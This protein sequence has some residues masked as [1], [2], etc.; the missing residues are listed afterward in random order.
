M[1]ALAPS[2][3]LPALVLS[4]QPSEPIRLAVLPLKV[5]GANP[6]GDLTDTLNTLVVQAALDA[7]GFQI[8][9]RQQ[10][11]ALL[12][13]SK[14]QASGL[15]DEASAATLGKHLGA[16]MV[17]VGSALPFKAAGDKVGITLSVRLVDVETASV[18]HSW[19]ETTR[20]TDLGEAFAQLSEK[21][22][23]RFT[24][25]ASAKDG[26]AQPATLVVLQEGKVTRI[27]RG[28]THAQPESWTTLNETLNSYQVLPEQA[29]TMLRSNGRQVRTLTLPP[30]MGLQSLP[31]DQLKDVGLIL[32]LTLDRSAKSHTLEREAEHMA[33]LSVQLF[34]MPD[35]RQV[36]S[37]TLNPPSVKAELYK[38]THPLLGA[39]LW[40]L[41]TFISKLPPQLLEAVKQ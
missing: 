15:V 17:V 11:Q 36:H 20:Q 1:R 22:R 10:V 7:K 41:R 26:K 28:K 30:G 9:E 24:Q 3:A 37:G 39:L 6:F 21:L 40:E 27:H 13:E 16:R 35:R 32:W 34:Q 5:E 19:M 12:K 29:A 14:Y 25:V 31:P 4:A 33:T 18:I 38:G 23:T 8:V 2:L